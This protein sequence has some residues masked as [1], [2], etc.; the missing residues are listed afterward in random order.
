MSK[1]NKPDSRGFVYS[2]DPNFQ[3]EEVNDNIEILLPAQQKLKVR[4]DTKHRAGK[5][6]T[7]IEGFIGKENDLQEL[8]R[9]L[10][11][12][13]GTGGSAKDG[14]IIIQGDQREKVMQWLGKNGYKNAKKI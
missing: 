5:A 11:S 10:K 14:E 1:K 9:K 6:V 7:L 8:G 13:C 4:L 3:F 2:T 12:F